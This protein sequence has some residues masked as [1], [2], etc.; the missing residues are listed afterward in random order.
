MLVQLN[1][2]QRT[3]TKAAKTPTAVGVNRLNLNQIHRANLNIHLLLKQSL[4]K[5]WLAINTYN[6]ATQ[7]MNAADQAECN[8]V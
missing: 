5:L 2:C 3:E 8:L 6:S 1:H 7:K 4:K